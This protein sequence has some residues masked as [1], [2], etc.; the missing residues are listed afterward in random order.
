MRKEYKLT[1][2][3]VD[4]LKVELE[5]LISGRGAMADKLK[6]A[7]DH[8]DLRENA[9]YHNARDEQGAME[10]RISKI[11]MILGS[12]EVLKAPKNDGKINLGNTVVLKGAKGEQTYILVGSVEANP[13]ERKISDAS[14]IGMALKGKSVGS[15]VVI[16]LP[17]GELTYTVKSIS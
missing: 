6:V 7:R 13:A 14:P 16:E 1:K 8:G 11:E 3:G 2:K 10:D 9:E 4:E 5:T 15:E 12:V 17:A